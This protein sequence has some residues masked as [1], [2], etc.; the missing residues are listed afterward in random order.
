MSVARRAAIVL[1]VVA[2]LPLA[3]ALYQTVS[4]RRE[5]AR[6]PPPGRLADI[7]GRRLHV[8]CEGAG[9]PAVIFESSGLG[10]ALSF[11]AVRA[12]VSPRTKPAATTAW[13]WG[14]AT[15]GPVR[16][17]RACSRTTCVRCSI[18]PASVPLTSWCPRRSAV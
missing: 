12:E 9:D 17:R 14:G 15:P 3:G 1:G 13:A 2:A 10:S 18:A 16:C 6:F 8:I 5:A 4:V 7:G 11:D